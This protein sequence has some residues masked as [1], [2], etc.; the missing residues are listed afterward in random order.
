ML[1]VL[2]SCY[3][4]IGTLCSLLPRA[5]QWRARSRWP[6]WLS[7]LPTLS[8]SSVLHRRWS[9]GRSESEAQLILAYGAAAFPVALLNNIY[10]ACGTHM[11]QRKQ[12]SNRRS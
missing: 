10:G 6:S 12:A 5:M 4:L 8:L 1:S 11:T 3:F 9:V 7:W 2:R